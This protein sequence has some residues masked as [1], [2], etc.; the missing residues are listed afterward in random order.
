[1]KFSNESI[2]EHEIGKI[3]NFLNTCMKF[4]VDDQPKF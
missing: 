3:S 4:L 1:M 2:H